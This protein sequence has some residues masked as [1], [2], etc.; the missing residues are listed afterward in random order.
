[1][2]FNIFYDHI[3]QSVTALPTRQNNLSFAT[4]L[5]G[6]PNSSCV[7]DANLA[8]LF[9]FSYPVDGIQLQEIAGS[10]KYVLNL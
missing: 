1:M 9:L 2:F 6:V 8:K 10:L 4:V 7:S 3:F 5:V